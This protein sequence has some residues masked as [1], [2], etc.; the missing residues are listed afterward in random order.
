MGKDQT[1]SVG[2]DREV[3]PHE[4]TNMGLGIHGLDPGGYCRPESL[5]IFI[6][7]VDQVSQVAGAG[8]GEDHGSIN[9][10]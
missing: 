4:V 1:V 3:G 2:G 9:G 8:E 6:Y 5:I 10:D 7:K